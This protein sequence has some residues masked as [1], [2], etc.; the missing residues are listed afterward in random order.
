MWI[1]IETLNQEASML[2]AI[3]DTCHTSETG[4]LP[5]CLS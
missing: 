3:Y 5:Q 4:Y 1:E 2:S